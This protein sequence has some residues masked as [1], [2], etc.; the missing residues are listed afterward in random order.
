MAT[1]ERYSNRELSW[2]A[3]DERVLE[4]ARRDDVP[5]L[6]RLKFISIAASN[7]DEFYMVRMGGLERRVSQGRTELPGPYSQDWDASELLRLAGK[8][9]LSLGQ[10]VGRTLLDVV[11]PELER[12]G[13]QIDFRDTSALAEYYEREVHPCLTPIAIDL[14]HPFPLLRSGSLNLAFRLQG[15]RLESEA[16]DLLAVVQVP[17]V[18]PRFVDAGGYRFVAMERLIADQAHSLFPGHTILESA[19]F[20]LTR[21]SDLDL[22][23]EEADDLLSTIEDEL[24]RRDRGEPVRLE[25]EL[26]ASLSLTEQLRE[27][28]DVSDRQIVK[29]PGPVRLADLMEVIKA[30]ELPALK[31]PP[32]QPVAVDRLRYAPTLFRSIEEGDVLLH[33]PYDAFRHVVD[34]LEQAASDPDVVAIKQTLYR[35]SGDSPIIRALKRAAEAGKEVTALVELKARFDEANNI[36]WARDLERSG[37]HVVYGL[38]GLKTHCKMLLVTRRRGEELQRFLHLGTGNYNPTTAKLY[39]DI[40]LLTS[41]PELTRDAMLLFNVLTGYAELPELRHLVVAPFSLRSHLLERIEI[42]IAHAIAGRPAGITAQM[43][44]LVDN[45]IIDALYWASQNGVEVDLLVRG[46]CCLRPQLQGVSENI[47][48]R[49]ILDRFLEHARI[50]WWRNGGDDLVYS[51]SADVMPRNLDRRIEVVFPILDPDA[52]SRVMEEVLAVGFRDDTFAWEMNSDGSYTPCSAQHGVRAQKA[53]MDLAASRHRSHRH[54][55]PEVP[56]KRFVSPALRAAHSQL[57]RAH[58]T[59]SDNGRGRS[60][61]R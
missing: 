36:A 5:A 22:A 50:F 10:A 21:A 37:V 29:S 31:D 17:S 53:F 39:T 18:L 13:V 2:L 42:E 16:E 46:I 43:N 8:R 34:F 41:R 40:S 28:V 7:L 55:R 1:A 20:R 44:S 49:S 58:Q 19:A 33:H 6:E 23:E 38:I 57:K 59:I 61:E 35:T 48:V 45:E 32:F 27:L 60:D 51:G 4:L 9:A 52:K 11:G 3:F 25:L 15:R 26:D 54:L 14:A 24:R 12:H 56:A 30:V 47:R